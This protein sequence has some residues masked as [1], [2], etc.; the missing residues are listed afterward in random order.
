MSTSPHQN[1]SGETMTLRMK[2]ST[3]FHLTRRAAPRPRH[4]QPTSDM[5]E[6][7]IKQL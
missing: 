7:S 2:P 6:V 5:N 3:L 4:N 1:R